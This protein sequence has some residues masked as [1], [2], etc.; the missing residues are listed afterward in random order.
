MF[1]KTM[2]DRSRSAGGKPSVLSSDLEITGKVISKGAIEISGHIKGE[3][4]GASVTLGGEGEI[5]GKLRA[6]TADVMGRVEGEIT[7]ET[8]TLRSS[9]K[10]R[11]VA[12]SQLLVI[13]SGATIEGSFSKPSVAQPEPLPPP[14][15]ETAP[16]IHPAEG[17]IE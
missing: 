13:E 7:A 1:G 8:L 16:D 11:I 15:A 6:G 12:V 4:D 5:L 14:I 3:I 17:G 2:E 10:A 9:A